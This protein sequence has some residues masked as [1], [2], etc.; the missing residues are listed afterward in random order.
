MK[1]FRMY[2]EMTDDPKIGVLTDAEFR[3]WVELLCLACREEKLGLTSATKDNINWLL[4]RDVTVTVDVLIERKLVT[5]NSE[6]FIKITRW[7]ERQMSSD[8]SAARMRKL[9][10]KTKRDV[11]SLK[12]DAPEKRREEKKVSKKNIQKENLV[13]EKFW[14]LFP[15]QRR[16]DKTK[17]LSA[18]N[19]AITKSTAEEILHGL[20]AYIGSN[21]VANGFAKGAT[22]WLNDSRWTVDYGFTP[23]QIKPVTAADRDRDA[24]RGAMTL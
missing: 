7:E 11:T 18:W 14:E 21:E 22:A 23:V 8:T 13:F 19:L 1:W 15:R 4:R 24:R 10:E 20:E 17:T 5:L 2:G 12:S 16:G 6:G 3:T 9:R